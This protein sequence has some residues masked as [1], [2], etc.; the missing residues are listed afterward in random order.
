[1]SRYSYRFLPLVILALILWACC[2]SD[3]SDLGDGV[4]EL[5]TG[6]LAFEPLAPDAPLVLV[7]G[8]QGG[9]HFIVNARIQGLLPGN[10]SRPGQLGNPL[11]RFLLFR[12]DGTRIDALLPPYRLGYRES[13][14]WHE[15]PSGTILR[16]NQEMIDDEGLVPAI[17]GER[18]RIRVEIRDASEE[19]AGA[20]IWVIPTQDQSPDAGLF[21]PDAGIVDAS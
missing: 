15:L 11:T 7:N 21:L 14:D 20:E 18:I 12:E 8:T 6:S 13:G 9:N 1:M 19:E 4:I 10:P 2:G 5:G 16:V 3:P 17:Y